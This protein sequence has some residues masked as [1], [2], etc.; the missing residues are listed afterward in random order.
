MKRFKRFQMSETT[1]NQIM[2]L[3]NDMQLKYFTAICDYGLNDVEPNFSGIENSVWIPMRDLIDYSNDRRKTNSENGKKGGA[4]IGNNNRKQATSSDFKQN[5]PNISDVINE[6]GRYG[7]YIDNSTAQDFLECG[8]EPSWFFSPHSFIEFVSERINEKYGGKSDGDKKSLFISAVKG[9]EDLRYEYSGWK[10]R[11]EKL[12]AEAMYQKEFEAT[13]KKHPT[14]CIHCGEDLYEYGEEYRC[15]PCKA[16]CVLNKN[17]L[18]WEW[19][20]L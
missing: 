12:D 8:L 7:F 20:S 6:A 10:N 2:A 14:K 16:F 19:R 9:W 3:P 5:Q 4:P 13:W 15:K 1:F 11:K 17:T 18:E